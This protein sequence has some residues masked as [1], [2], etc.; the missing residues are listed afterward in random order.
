MWGADAAEFR[1][2]RW[3]KDEHVSQFKVRA[4]SQTRC[5]DLPAWGTYIGH[6][7]AC[8]QFPVFNAGPRLCLGKPLA[9]LEAKTLMCM[10]ATRF[11]FQRVRVR[12]G[13]ASARLLAE[14]V[15]RTATVQVAGHDYGYKPSIILAMK[16]GMMA[17]VSRRKQ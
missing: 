14:A 5:R 15:S 2:E 12:S 6:V 10:L 3:Q 7:R 8:A 4:R 13:R 16:N 17:T 11:S 1:P 9:L